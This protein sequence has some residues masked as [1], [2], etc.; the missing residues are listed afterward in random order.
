MK[1]FAYF[2]ENTLGTND[3]KKEY[4][5]EGEKILNKAEEIKFVDE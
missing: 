3:P 4:F 1:K 2:Y 5:Y